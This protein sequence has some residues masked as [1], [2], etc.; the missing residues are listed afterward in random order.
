LDLIMDK[1]NKKVTDEEISSII[2]DSIRQAVGSFTSGSEMQEQ[3]EAAINYYTQ[4]PKGNLFPVGVSK[5]V[6]SDTMEIVDSYLAVISEL[7]LSN[8]KIAKFN[9]SD[10]TQTVAAGLASELTNHCIF[11]KNNGWVE[12]NTWIKGA[13]LFKNSIIRWKWEEQTGTKIEEY[14]NI[15]VLEVDALLSEG[16]AEI[17]EIRVGEGVDPESG[18]ETYEYVSIRKEIDK[19]KVALENIPPESFMINRDA[20][21]IATAN[22]VGIQTEMTLSDLREMGFDVDDN[23]GEGVEASN[24]TF[25]YESSVRQSINEVQQNFHEDFMGTANREVVVTES[26][27]KVDRDGD[28][29]AELKRFITVGE[30]ILLEE[31]ADSIPLA[32]LNP[33]EIPHAFYGMSIADATKSATEIK[34]TITRGMI[35]NV[36]LS[37][38]GRT[39]ADPNTVDFRALQS[40]EP[41]QII[42]TNGSPMSSVHTLV[43]AQLAPSTF[44]LLEYMNTEKEMATGMTRA[45]QGVNE[46]LFD[47]GNSAG[48]IAMVEQAAQKRISYV[49]RRFAETGFKDLCKGVYSLILDNSESILRDYSYYNITP[50]SLMDLENLTVDIDVGANSSAN[51]QENMMMMAQQVMPM[52]YQSPESKGII[53]PKAPFTIARQLLESMGIDNWVD[54]LVDPDTEQGQQQKQA[55]MQEAQQAQEQAG[56]EEQV[57]QQKIMLQLQK[58][59]ADIQKK[60]ADMELDREKFEYQKTKDAAELQ[61]ELALGEPT[62][63]G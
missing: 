20:T 18:E 30:E 27:I 17:V 1:K 16:N 2:N 9:P 62:K 15:S 49:A 14:E 55:A 46:K 41:H 61:L 21:S 56:K 35:E 45:A 51:T 31:Y 40:P 3:R 13:L 6:T 52:L 4:Q 47:S 36:Y 33:I 19:S 26:W 60:Q 34:T 44:S 58:Q 23:I 28:G 7:M 12:L 24:F 43:P 50:E 57:E 39:L 5:V 53:N 29:V 59:M 32:C 63:I 38:Y 48:K 42:P 25:D 22:F 54:F 10:P 11:T 8:G 37:N